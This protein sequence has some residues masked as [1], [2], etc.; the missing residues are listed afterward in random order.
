MLY[1][2]CV[3]SFVAGNY[4]RCASFKVTSVTYGDVIS[5]VRHPVTE[6][7]LLRLRTAS[8]MLYQNTTSGLDVEDVSQSRSAWSKMYRMLLP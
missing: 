5:V 3:N 4:N 7:Q 2:S 1:V 6:Q 8:Q